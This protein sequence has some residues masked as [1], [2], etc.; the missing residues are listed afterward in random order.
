MTSQ[1]A[2]RVT[3]ERRNRLLDVYLQNRSCISNRNKVVEANEGLVK[4]VIS[5]H[6]SWV[7]KDMGKI[8]YKRVQGES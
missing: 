6:F 5:Q 3:Q 4:K 7:P 2:A 8:C 1:P